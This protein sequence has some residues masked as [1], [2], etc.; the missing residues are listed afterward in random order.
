MAEE[1][2]RVQLSKNGITLDEAH[3]I[4]Q[5]LEYIHHIELSDHA[6]SQ[7]ITY[8]QMLVDEENYARLFDLKQIED[9]HQMF[10]PFFDH[11]GVEVEG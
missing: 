2:I 8:K 10:I 6:L 11:N 4:G 1:I 7:M 9:L 5:T 3:A